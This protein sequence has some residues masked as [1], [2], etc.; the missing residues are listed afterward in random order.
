MN[1]I[2]RSEFE[3]DPNFRACVR[4]ILIV[5]EFRLIRMIRIL[6]GSG[7]GATNH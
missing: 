5:V 3:S 4:K 1:P 2:R 7:L 6:F